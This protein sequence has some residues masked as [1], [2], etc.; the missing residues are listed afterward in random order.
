MT[1]NTPTTSNT[2]PTTPPLPPQ[3]ATRLQPLVLAWLALVVLTLLS[4][5]V[6]QW[7]HASLWLPLIVAA[8]IAIKGSV[9]ARSFIESHQA[10]PFIR[11]V[12]T[13]FIAISPIA[14]IL[15]AY[16]GPGLARLL[17]L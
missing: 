10:H 3:L 9:V 17:T 6:G 7:L 14:L 11:R 2:A 4:L 5:G 1:M 13:I 15:T 16:F 12:V 8:I